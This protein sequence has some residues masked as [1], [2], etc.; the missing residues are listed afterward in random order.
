[1]YGFDDEELGAVL[2]DKMKL[3]TVFVQLTL[4]SSQAAGIHEKA[5][6]AQEQWPANSVAIGSSEKGAI[7]HLKLVI[8]DSLDVVTGSTN[9]SGG[10]EAKQDNHL[11]VHRNQALAAIARHR[12]DLIHTAMLNRHPQLQGQK[13]ERI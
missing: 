13:E 12:V 5:L 10:A 3:E 6:L 9:W 8:V 11:S 1:M 2:L 4:D 7:M